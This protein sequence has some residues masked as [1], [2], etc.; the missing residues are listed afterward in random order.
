MAINFNLWT[1]W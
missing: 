1:I